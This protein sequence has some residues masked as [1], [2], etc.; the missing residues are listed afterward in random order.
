MPK[1]AVAVIGAGAI[2]RAHIE[3]IRRSQVCALAGIAEPG[4]RFRDRFSNVDGLDDL[5]IHLDAAQR[6][7]PGLQ[8]KRQGDV[9]QCQGVALAD[10]IVRTA[11]DQ[12]RARG[13]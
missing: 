12:E 6:F 8:M 4:V 3:T 10:W 11:D 13:E 9:R 1:I 7:M 5:D 2:G